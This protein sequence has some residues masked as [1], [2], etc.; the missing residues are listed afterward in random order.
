MLSEMPRQILDAHPQL[1]ER[2][3]ARHV[4]RQARGFEVAA[5]RLVRVGE[6]EVVHHLGEPVDLVFVQRERL[7]HLA[8]GA[9]AAVGDDVGGHRRAQPAVLLV[10]VLDDL[11]APVAARQIEIDVR[12]LAALLREEPL[13]Q[14]I[15]LDRIDRRDAQAVA[16][17]AVGGRAAP[18]HEDVVLPAVIDDVPDDE[19]V[20]GEIE[21]LDQI[22]LARDLR[23]G[24]VVIRP[25][26]IARAGLGDVAEERHLGF[27]GRHR[28]RRKAVAEIRHRVFEPL[29]QRQRS[30]QRVGAIGK[31]LRH[32][33]GRLEIALG[34]ARQPAAGR[35]ERRLVVDAGEHV[36]ERSILGRGKADAVGGHDRDAK[37]PRQA[38]ER[39]QVGFLVAQQMP[40]QLDADVGAAEQ[41]DQAIQQPAHAVVMRV[42][43][44]PARQRDEPGREALEL[45][46]REGAFS[47]GGAHLHAGHETAEIAV[48]R[49][50][51][52]PAQ[53]V[54][55]C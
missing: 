25:V 7:P 15:H 38:G 33:L 40:L 49:R 22:E 28:I 5:E 26:A 16:D 4:E 30:G 47:L 42:E 36:E 46:E 10:D 31:Q 6:L 45:L 29:G 18:L 37:R 50:P 13:E 54:A 41:A 8:R 11:L 39:H 55:R 48:A 23:A 51:M 52:P 21:L 35:I 43:H 1:G 44:R 12:P 53:A 17:R 9:A 34:V 2:A 27:A 20:A 19:E 14:Q 3:H 24:A 32:H